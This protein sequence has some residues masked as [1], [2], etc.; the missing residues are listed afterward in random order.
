MTQAGK[1]ATAIL[2]EV[3]AEHRLGFVVVL[4]GLAGGSLVSLA[5]SNGPGPHDLVADLLTL[6]G[7]LLI[8]FGFALFNF[9]HLDAKTQQAGFPTRLFTLPVPTR[10]LVSVR[11]LAGIATV[12]AL[13][14][15]WS[16]FVL[17]PLGRHFLLAWPTMV[18]SVAMILYQTVLWSLA[19][20][21]TGRV[22]ALGAGGSVLVALAIFPA[23]MPQRGSGYG[24]APWLALATVGVAA[25]LAA[26]ASVDRQR[27]A[28]GHGAGL[29]A[30]VDR[31]RNIVP[32]RTRPFRSAADAQMW[33]ELRHAA[34]LPAMT[35]LLVGLIWLISSVV[36]PVSGRYVLL[37]L[38]VIAGVPL[39]IGSLLGSATGTDHGSLP[40]VVVLRPQSNGDLIT[41]RFKAAGVAAVAAWLILLAFVP[42][43]LIT[44][45]DTG[46]LLETYRDYADLMAGVPGPLFVALVVVYLTLTT[47]K[48]TIKSTPL[49]LSGRP[50][51]VAIV[52]ATS[53]AAW[54]AIV[55]VAANSES[56]SVIRSLQRL[57]VFVPPIAWALNALFVLKVLVAARLFRN[58][59]RRGLISRRQ[60]VAWVSTWLLATSFAVA[61]F[62]AVFYRD[63]WLRLP[64]P[65]LPAL[66]GLVALHSF[67][68][69]RLALAPIALA[70]SRHKP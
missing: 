52:A 5:H 36:A 45:C 24:Y 49:A 17:R 22:V 42:L 32:A 7:V 1:A 41:T 28:G 57:F 50:A 18:L 47:W 12:A 11:L 63:P 53:A 25:Y 51:L 35:L 39:F 46:V 33:F 48:N 13:Y 66:A 4:A 31:V 44:C 30:L 34:I 67:P 21:R 6:L 14:L 58:N 56:E 26:L 61:L 8:G 23:V 68:L 9:T 54:V 20:L 16:T 60:T 55:I 59:L 65:W 15:A 40:A 27:H 2:W 29:R 43:W 62:G 19:S 70:R 3:Y 64:V 37:Y 38:A 10:T 69:V